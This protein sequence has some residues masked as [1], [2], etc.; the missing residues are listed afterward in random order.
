MKNHTETVYLEVFHAGCELQLVKSQKMQWLF[1]KDILFSKQN[2]TVFSDEMA[3]N[4][5]KIFSY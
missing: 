5:R 1:S 2:K 4:S 3:T